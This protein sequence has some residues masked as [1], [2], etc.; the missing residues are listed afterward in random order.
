MADTVNQ[1]LI[2]KIKM[3]TITYDIYDADAHSKIEG[4]NKS[5]TGGVHFCG[6]LNG[7]YTAAQLEEGVKVSDF[8]AQRAKTE[9]DKGI[10]G[11]GSDANLNFWQI[12]DMIIDAKGIEYIISLKG[13]PAVMV[14][15]KLGYNKFGEL[16]WHDVKDL[17]VLTGTE[18]TLSDGDHTHTVSGTISITHHKQ[19]EVTKKDVTGQVTQTTYSQ[20]D[21]TI[22]GVALG[23]VQTV[24]LHAVATRTKG[25][26]VSLSTGQ[27]TISAGATT[28]TDSAAQKTLIANAKALEDKGYS[29]RFV[30]VDSDT[31]DFGDAAIVTQKLGDSLGG[32][33]TFATGEV[34]SYTQPE[35]SVALSTAASKGEGD[36]VIHNGYEGLKLVTGGTAGSASVLTDISALKTGTTD[37]PVQFTVGTAAASSTAKL[38][39]EVGALGTETQQY[40]FTGSA[41]TAG[42]HTHTY[43]KATGAVTLA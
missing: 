38:V 12:G 9:V 39:T 29:M 26:A 34:A 28:S 35:F 2:K 14:W 3:G 22:Q 17:N 18:K 40:D 5:I 19:G 36:L 10:K 41:S 23:T 37:N 7:E 30:K 8:E 43:T 27:V 15:N 32:T 13:S 11:S 42:A 4:I 1:N 31:L 21:K 6:V 16:A 24:N 20:G 33:T 25:V